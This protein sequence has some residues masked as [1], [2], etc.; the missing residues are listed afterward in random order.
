[1]WRKTQG[2]EDKMI[3]SANLAEYRA[4][5]LVDSL[6]DA[7]AA[8]QGE[9]CEWPVIGGHYV[10]GSDPIEREKETA[11]RALLA[12]D[13]F[14]D[15]GPPDGPPLPLSHDE[16]EDMKGGR[17]LL[18]YIFALYARSLE[19]RDYDVKEHPSPANYVSGVLWEAERVAG[20]IGALPAYPGELAELRK[21]FPPRKLAGIGPGFCWEPPKLHAQTMASYRRSRTHAG[22]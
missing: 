14:A 7:N 18:N 13:W 4:R 20:D 19:G 8:R 3:I 12:R 22:S 6:F 16:R 10:S 9:I 11:V 15:N 21:R 17:G 2:Q 1:M 5:R